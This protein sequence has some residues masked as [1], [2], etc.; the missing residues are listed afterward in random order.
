MS[1]TAGLR[2]VT[3]KYDECQVVGHCLRCGLTPAKIVRRCHAICTVSGLWK[4]EE[5]GE[6]M[7]EINLR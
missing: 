6:G 1:V 5:V 4:S 7:V 2:V 3:C